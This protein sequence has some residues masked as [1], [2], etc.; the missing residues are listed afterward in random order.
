MR[1]CGLTFRREA[2]MHAQARQR[3]ET[4]HVYGIDRDGLTPAG[5]PGTA[6]R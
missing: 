6:R 5:P 3:D 4:V 1:A 2:V